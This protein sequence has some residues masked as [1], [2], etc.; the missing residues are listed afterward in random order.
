[1]TAREFDTNGYMEIKGNPLSKVGVFQYLGKSI[2]I[3]GLDP[4]G[5]YNVYRP[6]AELSSEECINSFKLLPW[7][8]EHDML[9]STDDGLLAP[10]EK[11]VQGVVGENVYFEDGYLRGNIKLFSESMSNDI[12]EGKEELSC[13]YRCKYQVAVGEFEGQEYDI[14]QTD[15][16]GNHLALVD[17][18]RM[19]R[20]VAVLD[21]S[22]GIGFDSYNIT[23]SMKG[24]DMTPEETKKAED[25]AKDMETRVGKMEKDME[26]VV[27]MCKD[28]KD[29]MGKMGKSK[30]EEEEEKKAADAAKEEEEKKAADAEKSEEEKAEDAKKV[31]EDQSIKIAAQDSEISDLKERLENQEKNGPQNYMKSVTQKNAMADKLSKHVG[32]FDHAEKSLDEVAK[33]GC[34][35]LDLECEAGQEVATLNGFLHNR[36]VI[37]PSK[38]AA[39]SQDGKEGDEV[40]AYLSH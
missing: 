8:D 11:G 34:D 18:G 19:G 39:V 35:K 28:M 4:E 12:D 5:I 1:M 22:D 13:G 15:I 3:P 40:S 7:V 2:G 27:D 16:R 23:K 29:M 26:G 10:E 21:K 30:D 36:P 9:G 32:T 25:A 37:N 38:F 24:F 6:E 17:Q 31:A 20:E 14:I 33:Y